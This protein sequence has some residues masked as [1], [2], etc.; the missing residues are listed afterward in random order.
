MSDGWEEFAER[1]P[2]RRA[3][4]RDGRPT[5][6]FDCYYHE[7]SVGECTKRSCPLWWF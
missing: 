4:V 6:E 5:G 1:C 3:V 2:Y 7:S